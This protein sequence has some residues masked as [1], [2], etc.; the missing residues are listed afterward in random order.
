MKDIESFSNEELQEELE[1]RDYRM[2]DLEYDLVDCGL[3]D[4][5]VSVF[6]KLNCSDRLLLRN[7]VSN[8]LSADFEKRNKMLEL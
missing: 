6:D 5:I 4:D 2:Y 8:F 3:F 1:G 7:L